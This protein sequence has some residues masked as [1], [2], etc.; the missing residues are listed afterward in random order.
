[1]ELE[2]VESVQVVKR[3]VLALAMSRSSRREAVVI[4]VV[5]ALAMSRS[6]VREAIVI[7]RSCWGKKL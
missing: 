3:V 4:G 7:R 6:R 1:V 5:L 2:G